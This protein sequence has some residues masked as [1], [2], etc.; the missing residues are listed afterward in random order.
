MKHILSATLLGLALSLPAF[1]DVSSAQTSDRGFPDGGAIPDASLNAWSDAWSVTGAGIPQVAS[2]QGPLTISN[3]ATGDPAADLG[4]SNGPAVRPNRVRVARPATFLRPRHVPLKIPIASLLANTADA[5][6]HPLHL[7]GVSASTNGAT[8]STNAT[9]VLYNV[10][11]A[12]NVND[13]FTHTV[14]DGTAT[15]SGPVLLSLQAEPTG[16]NYNQVASGRVNGKPARTFAGIPGRAYVVQ[17][18]QD[19][20]GVPSWTTLWTTNAPTGGLFQFTDPTPP[21]GPVFYRA[22][23]Q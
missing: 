13:R 6:G 23:H 2:G 20:A 4:P 3:G 9:Y 5:N 18:A 17:R 16:T 1:G 11:P 7:A 15:A 10:P 14:S 8:L 12:G 22:I 21:D 19:L